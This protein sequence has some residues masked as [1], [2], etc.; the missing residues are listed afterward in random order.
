MVKQYSI[1][2]IIDSSSAEQKL[3]WNF[4]FL[5]YGNHATIEQRVIIGINTANWEMNVYVARRMFFI[6]HARFTDASNIVY[7]TP[8]YVSILNEVGVIA[9]RLQLYQPSFNSTTGV[10]NYYARTLE[11]KNILCGAAQFSGATGF[12]SAMCFKI[13]Y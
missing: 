9:E 10:M 8:P 7:T 2:D 4:I 6:Y 5:R 12:G 11:V 3:I 13:T 1:Y